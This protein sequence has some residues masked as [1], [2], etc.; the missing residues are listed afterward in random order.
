MVVTSSRK[1]AGRYKLAFDLAVQPLADILAEV[2]ND[3]L[4]LLRAS[5]PLTLSS[6]VPDFCE[7]RG[8][9]HKAREGR[10]GRTD[11]HAV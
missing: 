1:A 7:R 10:H 5:F 2:L 9:T 3:D 11:S 8:P 4:R 6:L